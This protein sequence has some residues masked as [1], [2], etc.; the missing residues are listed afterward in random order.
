MG[1]GTAKSA[2]WIKNDFAG[3]L[4][5]AKAE[6]KRVFVA[7]TGYACTNCKWMK[8]N[9]FTRPEVAAALDNFILVEL[10][11]DGTDAE[12]EA[13]Q[14]RQESLFQTVAI[15]YYAIFDAEEKVVA[16]L[17]GLTKDEKEFLGFLQSGS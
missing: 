2:K 11:T 10:Y 16:T 15:P 3:A 1:G 9:L 13:N 17:G 8:A 6:N 14:K 5:Q 4:K 12:S 7:F